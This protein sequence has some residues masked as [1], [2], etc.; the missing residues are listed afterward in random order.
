M[1]HIKILGHI[2]GWGRY[3][4]LLMFIALPFSMAMSF[5]GLTPTLLLYTP[6]HRC[7]NASGMILWF[8]LILMYSNYRIVSTFGPAK[9][10]IIRHTTYIESIFTCGEATQV[11]K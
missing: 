3:Q 11:N 1:P 9:V 2:G 10:D 5:V 6:D 7:A 4:I 8:N